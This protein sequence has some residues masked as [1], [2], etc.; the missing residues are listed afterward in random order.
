[1]KPMNLNGKKKFYWFVAILCLIYG[2]VAIILLIQQSYFIYVR[3]QFPSGTF[4]RNVTQIVN[5]S[6]RPN[7]RTIMAIPLIVNFFGALISILAGLSLI[8]V[9][10]YKESKELK[11]EVIDSMV[12]PDEK[13]VIKELE[14]NNGILTQSEL[15]NNTGLSKVK[16][17]R[18]V[19]RL[20]S[21][22]IVKKY[23]YGITN[24]IKLEK[25]LYEE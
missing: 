4:A 8:S 14:N 25:I 1:M 16:V 9:L 15:V 7:V 24:K 5:T 20:E 10:R 23:P 17:H 2:G 19:K 6:L 13:T 3:N 12:M 18:I 21:L 11:Q 22:G